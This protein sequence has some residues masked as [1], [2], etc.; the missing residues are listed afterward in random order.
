MTTQ[1]IIGLVQKGADERFGE[2]IERLLLIL[3]SRHTHQCWRNECGCEYCRFINY[4][5]V[6]AKMNYHRIKKRINQIDYWMG[7]D[8][9][10]TL[11][12]QLVIDRMDQKRKI[13]M[14]KQ[15]KLELQENII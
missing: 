6:K 15:H 11:L 2:T 8:W 5:Y 9:E 13:H 3:R 4:E 14:L 7:L 1:Q 10:I 12:S